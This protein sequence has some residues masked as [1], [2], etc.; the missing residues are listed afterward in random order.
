MAEQLLTG[1]KRINEDRLLQLDLHKYRK[2]IGCLLLGNSGIVSYIS[3]I[4][5]TQIMHA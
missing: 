2:E 1:D 3:R 5:A 4:M